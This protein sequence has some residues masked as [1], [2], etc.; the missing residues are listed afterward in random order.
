MKCKIF[1]SSIIGVCLI[2]IY[3]LKLNIKRK[4]EIN[5]ELK[6]KNF[7]LEKSNKSLCYLYLLNKKDN[8]IKKYF[9]RQKI[10]TVAVY[11][12]NEIGKAFV[13]TFLDAGINICYGIDKNTNISF[14]AIEIR[15]VENID[16]QMDMIIVTAEAYFEEISGL[17]K[18]KAPVRKLNELLE[19]ILLVSYD[20]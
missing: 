2:I 3:K 19:E 9:D 20:Y 6:W 11:G 4:N 1:F 17:L 16:D 14:S 10:K 7:K 12:M 18:V 13:E 8:N 15:Q 5:K